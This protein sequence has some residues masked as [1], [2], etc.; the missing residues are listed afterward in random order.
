[1]KKR[2]FFD[3]I[4]SKVKLLSLFISYPI[5]ENNSFKK[6]GIKNLFIETK[7]FNLKARENRGLSEKDGNIAF[8]TGIEQI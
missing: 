2:H 7:N 5:K 8:R 1:M 6:M 3:N 4:L